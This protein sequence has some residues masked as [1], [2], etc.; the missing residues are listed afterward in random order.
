M[1]TNII[2]KFTKIRSAYDL[3]SL[4]VS[5][6]WAPVSWPKIINNYI[7]LEKFMMVKCNDF[8]SLRRSHLCCNKNQKQN[9]EE[10]GV[11]RMSKEVVRSSKEDQK[12]VEYGFKHEKHPMYSSKQ[13]LCSLEKWQDFFVFILVRPQ[14]NHAPL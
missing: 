5:I 12:E 9:F 13:S 7:E 1:V 2:N 6:E 11:V 8:E 4:F 3:I 10:I 14:H